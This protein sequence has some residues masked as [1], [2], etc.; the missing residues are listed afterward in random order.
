MVG[1]LATTR[2]YSRSAASVSIDIA[3]ELVA[4]TASPKGCGTALVGAGEI[5][6]R[7]CLTDKGALALLA[8]QQGDGGSHRRLADATLA[9]DKQQLVGEQLGNRHARRA[10]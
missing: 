7:F 9:G 4:D 2:R 3:D 6:F 10:T 8:R 1:T 5:P